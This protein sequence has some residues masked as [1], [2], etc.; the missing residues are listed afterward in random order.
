[1]VV[2]RR[3][4]TRFLVPSSTG[5]KGEVQT[6]FLCHEGFLGTLGAFWSYENMGIDGL[7]SH[8]VIREVLLGAPY[9]GQFPSSPLTREQENVG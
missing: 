9:T 8:E 2:M 1:S 6:T 7:A 3:L 5:S 4:W